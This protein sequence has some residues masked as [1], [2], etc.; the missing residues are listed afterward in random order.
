M[1]ILVDTGASHSFI[2]S[3]CA[4]S[5]KLIPEEL[6]GTLTIDSPLGNN[7][8]ANKLT[9]SCAIQLGEIIVECDLIW[10]NMNTYDVILGMDWLSLHQATIDCH[11]KRVSVILP[12]GVR[13]CIQGDSREDPIISPV[14][15]RACRQLN[16]LLANLT[17]NEELPQ[18]ALPRVVCEFPNVFPK[19]LPGLPPR[20]EIDFHIDLQPGVAP[21]S[22]APYRMAPAELQ[23]LKVQLEELLQLG[24]IR[25]SVSP[26]GAS[27]VFAK[28]KDG[29]LRLCIDYRKLNR[30]TIKNK[31]P[32]PRI[33]D[34]F[35][36]LRGSLFFSKIDLRSG[37]HQ[38]RIREEDIPKTAFRTRYGHYEF[39]VMPFGLTNAS[40]CLPLRLQ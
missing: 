32:L 31:Y 39:V 26:W 5:L 14:H 30:V 8:M 2:S 13:F 36:Q 20:R 40:S 21:I 1:V 19:E 37:Y 38:L 4:R 28:K 35:D 9:R 7:T 22:V 16:S 33:D 15:S 29:S 3:K 25:P 10:L 18:T 11:R 12:T 23:E 17:L 6:S 24:F 27:A 34:L